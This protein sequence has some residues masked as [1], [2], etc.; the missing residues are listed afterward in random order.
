MTMSRFP[1]YVLLWNYLWPICAA[2]LMNSLQCLF[3]MT[4][5]ENSVHVLERWLGSQ[6]HLLLLS[7]Q[8]QFPAPMWH[9]TTPVSGGLTSMGTRHTCGAPTYR[10]AKHCCM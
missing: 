10:Q 7:T 1:E 5:F 6:Q 9:L 8:V 3:R 2:L 4:L